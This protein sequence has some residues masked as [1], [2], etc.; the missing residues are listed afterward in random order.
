[1][2]IPW[3]RIRNVIAIL[4]ALY[5]I[6]FLRLASIRIWSIEFTFTPQ[7]SQPNR[8]TAR[9]PT[10][11]A[12]PPASRVTID[13]EIS[14]T[15]FFSDPQYDN[16]QAILWL[17][18]GT[19][20]RGIKVI[21]GS[22]HWNERQSL[23]NAVGKVR[24]SGVVDPN[25]YSFTPPT[26]PTPGIPIEPPIAVLTEAKLEMTW[27]ERSIWTIWIFS[28]WLFA[29]CVISMI[30]FNALHI[31]PE[32]NEDQQFG[33]AFVRFLLMTG[34]LFLIAVIGYGFS[35]YLFAFTGWLMYPHSEDTLSAMF[36]FAI[37]GISAC[38]LFRG[39]FEFLGWIP[40]RTTGLNLTS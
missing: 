14:E 16:G 38:F 36:G 19:R 1:M 18:S 23:Q 7:E 21:F 3:T 11:Q 12:P 8:E 39:L 22:R 31:P 28:S 20:E 30:G 35:F 6:L 2:P 15:S 10:W 13:E 9:S 27:M 37:F 29:V 33:M 26:P 34:A 17:R 5:G 40:R 4:F 32:F 25:R 24:V